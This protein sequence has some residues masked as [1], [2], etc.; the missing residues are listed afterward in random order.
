MKQSPNS[1]ENNAKQN[2]I[3]DFSSY[4]Y[5]EKR[6]N[7]YLEIVFLCIGTDR[8]I[9]DC[10]GPLVGTKLEELLQKYNIFNINIYGT[11]KENICYTNIEK[12]IKKFIR[13]DK[14]WED[15]C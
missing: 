6:A 13:W 5:E 2:F 9:G 4:I 1:S 8:L 10:F 15:I 14:Y 11:L 7:N 12:K 3:R